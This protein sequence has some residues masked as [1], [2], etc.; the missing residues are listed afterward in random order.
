MAKF[1]TYR[2]DLGDVQNGSQNKVF[3]PFDEV[4]KNEVLTASGSC[5]C[6][7]NVKIEDKGISAIYNANSSHTYPKTIPVTLNKSKWGGFDKKGKPNNKVTLEI[8]AHVI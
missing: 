7:T 6:T 5:G 2:V 8:F 1:K 3:F 4:K